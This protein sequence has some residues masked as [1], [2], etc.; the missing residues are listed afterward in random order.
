M[1]SS[2]TWCNSIKVTYFLDHRFLKVLTVKKNIIKCDCF[3]PYYLIN[4]SILSLSLSL[5]LFI[6]F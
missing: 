2:Y 1:G 3:L 5:S 6:A 4:T